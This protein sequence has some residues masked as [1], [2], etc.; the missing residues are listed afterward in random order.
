MIPTLAARGQPFTLSW[1]KIQEREHTLTLQ[2][3]LES[4]EADV[5]RRGEEQHPQVLLCTLAEL[6]ILTKGH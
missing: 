5:T 2:V 6:L 4:F 1:P 3:L